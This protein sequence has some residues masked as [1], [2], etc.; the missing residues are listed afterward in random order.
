MGAG[1][2][3]NGACVAVV[4]E[5]AAPVI[6]PQLPSIKNA[7][8]RCRRSARQPRLTSLLTP[9]GPMAAFKSVLRMPDP[10]LRQD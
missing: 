7:Q 3:A 9:H 6:L 10:S 4:G 1:V 5:D 8:G 2:L